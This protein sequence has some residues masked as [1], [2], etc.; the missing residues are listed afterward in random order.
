MNI[1]SQEIEN[2]ENPQGCWEHNGAFSVEL[3]HGADK[4]VVPF[5]AKVDG[6]T[7]RVRYGIIKQTMGGIQFYSCGSLFYWGYPSVKVIRD[8]QGKLLWVNNE[9]C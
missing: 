5:S 9:H 8:G 7:I 2:F 3:V 1:A 4:S 6:D